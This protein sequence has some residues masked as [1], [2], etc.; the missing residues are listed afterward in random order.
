MG[1][2]KRVVPERLANKLLTIRERLDLSQA[3]MLKRLRVTHSR[4]RLSA[5]GF[6]A[7]ARRSCDDCRDWNA[8][9]RS[10]SHE[11]RERA[12]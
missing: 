1:R 10:L 2:G 8:T 6:T 12:S 9:R 7:L 11:A 4:M 3:E 5:R